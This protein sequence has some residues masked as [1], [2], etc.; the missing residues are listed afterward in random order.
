MACS[1]SP[2]ARKI[3]RG[4][5]RRMWGVFIFSLLGGV[6]GRGGAGEVVAALRYA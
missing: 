5:R 4:S 1:S 6:E 3:G 2:V